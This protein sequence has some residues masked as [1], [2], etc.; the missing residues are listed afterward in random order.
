[1]WFIS[2]GFQEIPHLSNL[3]HL[4]ADGLEE[5]GEIRKEDSTLH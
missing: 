1:M 4:M 5:R 2:L 3:L